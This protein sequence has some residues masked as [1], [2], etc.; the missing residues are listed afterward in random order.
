[1]AYS[2]ELTRKPN[3]FERVVNMDLA[4]GPD[5]VTARTKSIES[6]RES[7]RSLTEIDEVA[8]R[9]NSQKSPLVILNMKN[10]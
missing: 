5:L 2:G 9:H 7:S 10:V 6:I 1:M 4:N 3:E 8:N